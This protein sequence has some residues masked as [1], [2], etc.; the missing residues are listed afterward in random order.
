MLML[1][2]PPESGRSELPP[3]ERMILGDDLRWEL[4]DDTST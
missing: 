4:Q 1:G 3:A 2:H